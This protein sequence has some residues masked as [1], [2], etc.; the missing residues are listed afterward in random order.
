MNA[1]IRSFLMGIFVMFPLLI[2]ANPVLSEDSAQ[3]I[4]KRSDAARGGNLPGI[5]WNVVLTAVDGERKQEQF[6][7]IRAAGKN[8][9]V[10]FERP[11]KIKGQKLLM[12]ENNMWFIRPGLSKPVPISARQRLVGQASNGDVAATRYSEDYSAKLLGE[13]AVDGE[14]CYI[15][16]LKASNPH[17]TYD[18]LRYWV[19]KERY[20]AV[21]AEFFTVSGKLFKSARFEYGNRIDYQGQNIPFVSRMHIQDQ[22]NS[23]QWT[24]L[25]YTDIST[26][27]FSRNTFNLQSLVR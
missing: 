2:F 1:M 16:D 15:L 23:A 13:E 17:V 18:H 4:L 22:V 27:S 20:V 26:T 11:A 21:K 25:Q 3:D 14:N 24:S 6:L 19:S 10:E 5:Q 9:L 8:S 12:V 7:T